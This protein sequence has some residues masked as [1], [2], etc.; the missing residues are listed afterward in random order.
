MRDRRMTARSDHSILDG[1]V[2]GALWRAGAVAG[3]YLAARSAAN[4]LR[5]YDFRN[6]LVVITGGSRGL[7]LLVARQLADEG[8][9]LVI[10]ARDDEE[11][12]N[13]EY[14]LR[15]RAPF[16]AA[17]TCDLTRPDDIA[18]LFERIRHEVG[19][20]DVLI[21][22]AGVIQV[23][24]METMTHADYEQAMAVHFW[25]PLLCAEQVI[26]DM[27]RRRQG[28]IVNISSIGGKIAVPH[29]LPYCASKYALVGLSK[30]MRAELMKDG[31]YV[32]TVCPG[33]MRT[34]S[35]RHA[36]FKGKHRAEYAW[37]SIGGAVPGPSMGAERAAGQVI[38]AC[39]Y[40]RAEIVLSLPAKLAA[41]IDELAPELTADLT[42]IAARVMPSPGGIGRAAAEGSQSTSAWSPSFL[43]T[44][45]ERAAAENNQLTAS[46]D[47]VELSR[48]QQV[49][50]GGSSSDEIVQEASEESFP[51]SDAPSWSPTTSI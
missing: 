46:K 30:G 5:E 11:L 38:N 33:L 18:T 45:N 6:R 22:N 27:R 50:A 51:A 14:E 44:L 2:R 40:G 3:A 7:G 31:I 20:V 17:Y 35:P 23:G 16:V 43:T 15:G 47:S 39:R 36:I 29:L 49:S 21:N 32:T 1:V 10:C 19:S 13:A 4:W 34:G 12:A 48:G 41:W 24:P 26:P 25:A 8:A 28:R 42:A 9:S 37:F